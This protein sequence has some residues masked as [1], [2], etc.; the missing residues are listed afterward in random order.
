[1]TSMVVLCYTCV[2][3]VDLVKALT[4]LHMMHKRFVPSTHITS[5][6]GPPDYPALMTTITVPRKQNFPENSC[7]DTSVG[8]ITDGRIWV[9][10]R[11]QNILV[12]SNFVHAGRSAEDNS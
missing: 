3:G 8:C 5:K 4:C 7:R 1:M 12:I 2:I 10:V 6:Y 11:C 9:K